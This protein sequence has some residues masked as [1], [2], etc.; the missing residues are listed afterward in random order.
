MTPTLLGRMQT[1][2]LL[3]LVIGLPITI[4]YAFWLAEASS[5]HTRD[6]FGLLF[7]I[8]PIQ[9]LCLLL[10]VGLCLDPLYFWL[11]TFRWDNDWPFSFQ[12]IFSIVEFLIVL[13]VI[14]LDLLPFMPARS[15]ATSSEYFYVAL[16]FG[17]VFI[18][19][20]LALL[21]LVQLFMIR[22]RFKGGEWGRL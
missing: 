14:E 19:S 2:I 11:Q 8:R 6:V 7:D 16:H 21:G 3:F 13:S 10:V 22:W 20:F 9:I 5:V 15:I 1:R 18:P 12:F 4:I 17:F